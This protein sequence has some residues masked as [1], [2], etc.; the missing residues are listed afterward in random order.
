M[1]RSNRDDLL[2]LAPSSLL[3]R[4]IELL[5]RF[6]PDAPDEAEVPDPYYGDGDGF[7]R[8]LDICE[9]ACIGL[10]EHLRRQH[11]L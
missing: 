9:A 4:K 5:R 10:L 3:S 1:D 2:R 6:D 11:G 8:V 7:E